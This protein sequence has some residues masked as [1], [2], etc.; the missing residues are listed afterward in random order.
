MAYVA[1]SRIKLNGSVYE[2]G[3]EVEGLTEEQAEKLVADKVV[4]ETATAN[5]AKESEKELMDYT[6]KELNTMAAEYGVEDPESYGTKGELVDAMEADKPEA[7]PEVNTDADAEGESDES[8][9]AKA[10]DADEADS[11]DESKDKE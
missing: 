10:D 6:R 7:E 9:E 2:A 4:V 8:D 5:E 1:Q 3:D 11:D